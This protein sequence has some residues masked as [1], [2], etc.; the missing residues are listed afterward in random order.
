MLCTG[1]ALADI[2]GCPEADIPPGA[3]KGLEK[4]AKRAHTDP[5]DLGT[6]YYCIYQDFAR[7]TVDTVPV[8]QSDGGERVSTLMCSGTADRARG[9]MCEVERYQS[10]RVAPATGQPEARVEVP[11]RA[12]P[13]ATRD[14]AQ[15]VFELLNQ[16]ARVESCTGAGY[17]QTTE[18]LRS[19]LARRYGPYRL[20]M[21]REGFA[22]LRGGVQVRIRSATE[23]NPRAQ[24]QC[25]EEVTAAE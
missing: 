21:S 14:Y 13:D 17:G 22:L 2:P 18:S 4:A 3:L 16:P 19:M 25:W 24:I 10:I 11:E 12:T 20:V 8:P 7:A 5:L 6:L 23:L 9:W 15:R 1:S